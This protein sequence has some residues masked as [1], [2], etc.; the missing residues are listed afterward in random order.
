MSG[1]WW[2][3]AMNDPGHPDHEDALAA[4]R[5]AEI[6]A[7]DEWDCADSNAYQARVDAGL[8]PEAEL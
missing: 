1:S 5:E 4:A 3:A 2:A 6:E 7:A 8:E